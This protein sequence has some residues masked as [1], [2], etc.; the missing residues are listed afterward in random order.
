LEGEHSSFFSLFPS[1]Q[2]SRGRRAQRIAIRRR[3]TRPI[4][5][6]TPAFPPS[7]FSFFP[8][9]SV[10]RPAE[11]N[12][13]LS[14]E[15]G[16]DGEKLPP[17]PFLPPLRRTTETKNP[18][19]SS[20]FFSSFSLPSLGRPVMMTS[21]IEMS[22]KMLH[23]SER[24]FSLSPFPLSLPPLGF[25]TDDSVTSR[26]RGPFSPPFFFPFSPL[27]SPSLPRRRERQVSGLRDRNA[28]RAAEPALPLLPSLSFP[29]SLSFLTTNA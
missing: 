5:G 16:F 27:F 22:V 25:N 15:K 17:P 12:A 14:F 21:A 3:H 23:R 6:R 8:P 19:S 4:K 11:Y 7:P 2:S 24:C 26:V 29:F 10:L 20:S 13:V 28:L 1:S 18:F 9:S